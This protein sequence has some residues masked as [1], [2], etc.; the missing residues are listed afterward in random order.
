MLN[1]VTT[2]LKNNIKVLDV[3]K[4]GKKLLHEIK[5]YKKNWVIE[6]KKDR[7]KLEKQY[8]IKKEIKTLNLLIN[9]ISK[10]YNI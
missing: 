1:L 3:A 10:F 2:Y 5:N 8:S 9:K 7:I 4:F 6:T